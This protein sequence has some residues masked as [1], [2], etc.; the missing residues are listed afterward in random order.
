MIDQSRIE[1]KK[2]RPEDMLRFI[3]EDPVV[4]ANAR[5]NLLS[6]PAVTVYLDNKLAACGG[7]RIRGVGEAWAKY[8]PEALKDINFLHES[9]KQID[10]MCR[11]NSIWRLWSEVS[12]NDEKHKSFLRHMNFTEVPAWCRLL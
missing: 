4:A 3:G 8:S 5:T 6:G 10:R 11:E 2:F 12:I 7:I 1:I 9:Q